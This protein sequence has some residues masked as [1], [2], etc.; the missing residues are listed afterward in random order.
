MQVHGQ[1]ILGTEAGRGAGVAVHQRSSSA[2]AIRDGTQLLH[3]KLYCGSSAGAAGMLACGYVFSC[4]C[5]MLPAK[6]TRGSCSSG[7]FEAAALQMRLE[8]DVLHCGSPAGA[9]GM[10][11]ALPFTHV[12]ACSCQQCARAKSITDRRTMLQFEV[13]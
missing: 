10:L 6:Y 11:A 13:A 2:A 5:F 4:C 8:A 7:D 1:H 12:V 9:A 3:S